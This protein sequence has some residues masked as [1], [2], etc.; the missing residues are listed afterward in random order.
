MGHIEYAAQNGIDHL[1][2]LRA[3]HFIKRCVTGY[4]GVVHQDFSGSKIHLDLCNYRSTGII[5]DDILFLGFDDN[6]GVKFCRRIINAAYVAA[7]LYPACFKPTEIAAP[8]PRDPPVMRAT[9][10]IFFS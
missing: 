7:T 9:L 8:I 2:P 3:G 5:V 4:A 6:L 10:G 1:L